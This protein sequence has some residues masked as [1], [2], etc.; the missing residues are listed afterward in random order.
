MYK[1]WGA[2]KPH[3]NHEA[4]PTKVTYAVTTAGER[5]LISGVS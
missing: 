5:R 1:V 2:P 4:P 3:K